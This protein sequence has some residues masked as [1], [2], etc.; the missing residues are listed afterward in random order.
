KKRNQEIAHA[1]HIA[2][3]IIDKIID[4]IS[5]TKLGKEFCRSHSTIL[6]SCKQ[7]EEYMNKNERDRDI[8]SDIISNL[9]NE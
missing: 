1:R 9:K 6:Y 5:S 7:V 8:I 4:D 2:V 3:Y